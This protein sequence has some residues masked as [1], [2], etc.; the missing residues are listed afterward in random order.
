MLFLLVDLIKL[1]DLWGI[2]LKVWI[3]TLTLLNFFLRS[4]GWS[5]NDAIEFGHKGLDFINVRRNDF[6]ISK[7]AFESSDFV[8]LLILWIVSIDSCILENRQVIIL[9]WFDRKISVEIHALNFCGLYWFRNGTYR[10]KT[11]LGNWVFQEFVEFFLQIL[12]SILFFAFCCIFFGLI[13]L[14]FLFFLLDLLCFNSGSFLFLICTLDA[15]DFLHE[16][17]RLLIKS[18]LA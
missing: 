15:Q 9:A 10:L 14:V 11:K 3:N 8:N 16:L 12:V 5:L 17:W 18:C 13:F 1:F 6:E 7:W 4:V 2:L